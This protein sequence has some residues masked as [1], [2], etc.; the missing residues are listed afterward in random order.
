MTIIEALQP[1]GQNGSGMSN[2]MQYPPKNFAD[3]FNQK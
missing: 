2:Y 3:M 1:P